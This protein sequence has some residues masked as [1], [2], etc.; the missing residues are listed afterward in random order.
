MPDRPAMIFALVALRGTRFLLGDP[1]ILP[2]PFTMADVRVDIGDGG[3]TVRRMA[4]S[5]AGLIGS[6]AMGLVPNAIAGAASTSTYL[7]QLYL[8]PA[9]SIVKFKLAGGNCVA[10]QTQQEFTVRESGQTRFD[11]VLDIPLYH[12]G[13][14]CFYEIS[15]SSWNV[16]ANY[17]GKTYSATLILS[18]KPQWPLIRSEWLVSCGPGPQ[19]PY[20]DCKTSALS[21]IEGAQPVAVFGS[22]FNIVQVTTTTRPS[23]SA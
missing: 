22:P 17:G 4:L 20:L 2:P 15:S 5:L 13:E 7:H 6:S 12:P 8:I 18:E 10:N 3:R 9:G 19:R 1:Q 11:K 23:A 16:Y 14:S 21:K